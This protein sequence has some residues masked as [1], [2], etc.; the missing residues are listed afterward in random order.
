[1]LGL[2]INKNNNKDIIQAISKYNKSFNFN[3]IQLFIA[4]PR[5]NDIIKDYLNEENLIKIASQLENHYI[6]I[7]SNYNMIN[8]FNDI[9]EK[10]FNDYYS[11]FIVQVEI[12]KQIK[13][14]SL[15]LHIGA[16]Q[17]PQKIIEVT[18]K[19]LK[20]IEKTDIKLLLEPIATT[21][22]PYAK[23]ENLNMITKN[24]LHKNFGICLD[25][26]HLWLSGVNITNKG[27]GFLKKIKR[28]ELIHL[29]GAKNEFN[30]G[31]DEH[32]IAGIKNDKIFYGKEEELMKIMKYAKKNNIPMIME[33]NAKLRQHHVYYL[34]NLCTSFI[35]E[36]T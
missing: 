25:T 21:N 11:S 33:I 8:I 9:N 28:L 2:H 23:I 32:E 17:T 27:E 12:A 18:R 16:H 24:I 1:M 14:H 10:K 34:N 19:L 22:N 13:A 26:A 20:E 3:S 29:N 36:T 31:N 4:Q 30:S 7:H 35:N 15:V 6:A 5:R